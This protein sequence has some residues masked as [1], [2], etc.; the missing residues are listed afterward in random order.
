[1]TCLKS[2]SGL[3]TR[4]VVWVEVL[5]D[6][7]VECIFHDG[8]TWHDNSSCLSPSSE[9]RL[10][11]V[12]T[13]GMAAIKVVVEASKDFSKQ[14]AADYKWDKKMFYLIERP[15]RNNSLANQYRGDSALERVYLVS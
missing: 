1:M 6:F 2:K 11:E 7:D 9:Y 3:S 13:G 10:S 5:V 8:K 15:M 4:E 14:L 12:E